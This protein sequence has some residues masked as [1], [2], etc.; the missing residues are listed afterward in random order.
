CK[1]RFRGGDHDGSQIFNSFHTYRVLGWPGTGSGA[2]ACSANA[3]T[4]RAGTASGST[5]PC[6]NSCAGASG[7]SGISGGRTRSD[8]LADRALSGSASGTGSGCGDILGPDPRCGT[9][10]RCPPLFERPGARLGDGRGSN[11]MGSERPGADSVPVGSR[12]DGVIH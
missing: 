9:L 1:Y 8:Y 7:C 11:P 2:V 10:G 6:P 12:D 4:G 5:A 3:A